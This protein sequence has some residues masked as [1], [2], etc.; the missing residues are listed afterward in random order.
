MKFAHGSKIQE[1]KVHIVP[2]SHPHLEARSTWI[3]GS[4]HPTVIGGF[5]L[6][7]PIELL[8][9]PYKWSY[10]TL[11]TYDWSLICPNLPIYTVIYQCYDPV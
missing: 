6:G 2:D 1:T 9:D 10:F 3:D 11:F 7:E 8:F 5:F 4:P